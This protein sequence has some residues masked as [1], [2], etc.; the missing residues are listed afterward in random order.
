MNK[1]ITRLD[2]GATF[3]AR[4]TA[5]EKNA[6]REAL[7]RAV[8]KIYS[9]ELEPVPEVEEVV[10]QMVDAFEAGRARHLSTQ[11]SNAMLQIATACLGPP[12]DLG[13][14]VD[15]IFSSFESGHSQ[16]GALLLSSEDHL[17][18]SILKGIE[19]VAGRDVAAQV[20]RLMAAHR[21]Q[22]QA[23]SG[24]QAKKAKTEPVKAFVEELWDRTPAEK[25]VMKV[26]WCDALNAL[27][28]ES[29]RRAAA[30]VLPAW[31]IR[32]SA[33]PNEPTK[34]DPNKPT[35]RTIGEWIT[36]HKERQSTKK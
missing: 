27:V 32:M 11:L 1:K 34:A 7:S 28:A 9:A 20:L 36:A 6:M 26:F 13:Q 24:P 16:A 29:K 25:R 12:P 18:H 4:L 5:A 15:E 22:E 3:D 14:K 8:L 2:P 23:R 17:L 19:S 35:E 21:V 31:D 30:G 10:A 33:N